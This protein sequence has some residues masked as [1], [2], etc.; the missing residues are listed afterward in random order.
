MAFCGNCGH[1]NPDGAKFCAGCGADLTN[2]AIGNVESI[3]NESNVASIE[4]NNPMS[5]VPLDNSS[6]DSF[7]FSFER[8]EPK[9][10]DHSTTPPVTTTPTPTP[11]VPPTPTPQPTPQPTPEPKK[12]YYTVQS[13]DTLWGISQKYGISLNQIISLNPQI[14]NP[15]LIYPGQKVRVK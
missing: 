12:E 8:D 13:G 2:Q 6:T 10:E 9:V 15:D 7:E 5:Y 3:V 11:V 1:Q 14:T 4:D